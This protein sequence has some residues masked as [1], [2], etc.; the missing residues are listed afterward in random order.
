MST[1]DRIASNSNC[2][3]TCWPVCA[4]T[5]NSKLAMLGKLAIDS[6]NIFKAETLLT[7]KCQLC[8]S[9]S[10]FSLRAA[11]CALELSQTLR[12]E[13][14]PV[15][16]AFSS[17]YRFCVLF[18]ADRTILKGLFYQSFS[19][20]YSIL[21]RITANFRSLNSTLICISSIIPTE[22]KIDFTGGSTY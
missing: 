7:S 17:F 8:N 6:Y 15:I 11:F 16:Q 14:N 21:L 10:S 2:T 18:L 9:D 22:Y 3:F 20:Y 5:L 19:P 12:T 4:A 13:K 1:S